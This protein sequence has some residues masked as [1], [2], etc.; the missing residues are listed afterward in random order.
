MYLY[1]YILELVMSRGKTEIMKKWSLKSL[2]FNLDHN[3]YLIVYTN[4]LE[5]RYN[6]NY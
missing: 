2:E 1:T 3:F 6:K 4:I 5:V